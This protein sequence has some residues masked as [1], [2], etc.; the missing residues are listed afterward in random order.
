MFEQDAARLIREAGW[1]ITLGP[2]YNTNRA[3]KGEHV[4]SIK[5][6]LSKQELAARGIQASKACPPGSQRTVRFRGVVVDGLLVSVAH[7]TSSGRK[8]LDRRGQR[9]KRS[10][11]APEGGASMGKVG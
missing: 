1:K 4:W 2:F 3:R 9:R 11:V 5:S 8:K 6:V 10:R 7:L